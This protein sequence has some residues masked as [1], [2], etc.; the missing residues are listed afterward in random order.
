VIS[1]AAVD[2]SARPS[3]AVMPIMLEP[4]LCPKLGN[5]VAFPRF[6]RLRGS[7]PGPWTLFMRGSESGRGH[8]LD[9][10]WTLSRAASYP[11]ERLDCL[12]QIAGLSLS[13]RKILD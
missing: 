11:Q 12:Y 2:G 9:S 3:R 4:M 7:P 10:P 6:G 13:C 1:F 5:R 8:R